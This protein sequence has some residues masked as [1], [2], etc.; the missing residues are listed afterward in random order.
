MSTLGIIFSDIHAWNVAELNTHRTIASI[1]FAG[2][3]RLVDFTLSNMVNSDIYKIGLITKS[4]YQSLIEHIGS[5]KD[6]DLSRKNGG[7]AILPPYIISGD[8]GPYKGRLDALIRIRDFIETSTEEY[9]L[10]CDCDFIYN[11]DF[12][13]VIKAHKKSGAD[14]TAVYTK[15]HI[16][17]ERAKHSIIYHLDD[18]SCVDDILL[19]PDIEGEH[20]VGLNAWVFSRE[21]L[22]HQMSHSATHGFKNF[23][24]HVLMDNLG[25]AKIAGYL[26]EG[27]SAHI[28][29]LTSFVDA[30]MDM[31]K[32]ECRSGLFNIDKR[33]IH[34]RVR[35]SSPTKYGPE[36]KVKNSLI[37]DGC[38]IEGTVENSILFRGVKVSRGSVV[39]NSILMQDTRVEENASLSWIIADRNVIIRDNKQLSA[40]RSYPFYIAKG[41][42]I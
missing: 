27:Y 41:K 31:I 42:M 25:H 38:V 10:L 17:G 15:T 6:W 3:Y 18:N 7:V 1:P 24:R 30:N 9:V 36:A 26:H 4:N 2:R 33:P 40:D 37:A 35:D 32:K 29:S 21:Y 22:L 20:N 14:I 39:K 8:S 13:H 34:T 28:E 16:T 19:N 23:F 11:I 5:G 12:D